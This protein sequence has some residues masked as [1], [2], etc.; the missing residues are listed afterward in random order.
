MPWVE[1]CGGYATVTQENVCNITCNYS[2]PPGAT[3]VFTYGAV[4]IL[5]YPDHPA[6]QI[7]EEIDLEYRSSSGR[8]FTDKTSS[9][10]PRTKYSGESI[11]EAHQHAVSTSNYL[12]VTN[13]ERL[14]ANYSGGWGSY[15][16]YLVS[17][18]ARLAYL[19]NGI[20]EEKRIPCFK[21]PV[22]D[23]T[24]CGDAY[25]AGFITGLSMGWD[26]E[27]SARL[28]SAAGSLVIQGLGSDAGIVNLEK[29]IEFMEKAEE[30]P[31]G[32]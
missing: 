23:S 9:P 5:I 21:V 25:C 4:P 6:P 13:P 20:I 22:V 27:K 30:V 19:K 26:L 18:M 31:L 1:Y 32:E 17:S 3:R 24:G 8:V 11:A 7:G 28:G 14:Y 12:I 2:I 16:D 15:V 10:I 29:T